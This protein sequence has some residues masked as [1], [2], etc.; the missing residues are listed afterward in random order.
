MVRIPRLFR[1]GETD[2]DGLEIPEAD[3][4]PA[5]N[6]DLA[7]VMMRDAAKF[8]LDLAGENPDLAIRMEARAV[9]FKTVADLVEIDPEGDAPDGVQDLLTL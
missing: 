2:A 4:P 5:S 7:V 1:K 9:A 6:L 3:G 8:Y